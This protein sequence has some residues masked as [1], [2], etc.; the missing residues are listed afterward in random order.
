MRQTIPIRYVSPV[1]RPPSE[2]Q[3]LI[4][5]VTASPAGAQV[6]GGCSATIDGQDVGSARSARDA[7]SVDADDTVTI[8]G[9]APGPITGRAWLERARVERDAGNAKD[10]R[11]AYGRAQEMLPSS[12]E[13]Q[14]DLDNLFEADIAGEKESQT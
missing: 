8:V 10:A 14:R 2:G 7:I 9:N 4:L 1:F 13:A 11:D 3:S 5:P 12:R 6:T